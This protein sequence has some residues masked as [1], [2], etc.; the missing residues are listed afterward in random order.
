MK[1]PKGTVFTRYAMAIA[2]S[3]GDINEAIKYAG[4]W[5]DTSPEVLNYFLKMK[6]NGYDPAED[7][8]ILPDLPDFQD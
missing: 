7:W 4:K 8:T 5:K 6:E 1:L 3:K 2:Y